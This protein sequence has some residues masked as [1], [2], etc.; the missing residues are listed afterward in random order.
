MKLQLDTTNKTIV[1]E[2]EVNIGEFVNT[3]KKILPNDLWKEFKLGVNKIYNWTNPIIIKEYPAYPTYPTY[4]WY[5]SGN[6]AKILNDGQYT[7]EA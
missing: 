1:I 6:S 3:L 5:T 2:E 7:I 4:P